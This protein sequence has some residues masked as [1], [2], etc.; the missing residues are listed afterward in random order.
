VRI[1]R[2]GA[3]AD[4]RPVG[5]FLGADGELK[6][7]LANLIGNAAHAMG[8]KGE[9]TVTLAPTAVGSALRL[10]VADSGTGMSAEIS[11]RIFEPFYTTKGVGEGTGLGLSIVYGIVQRWGG[12]IQVDSTPGT[13]TRFSIT[14]PRLPDSP[15]AARGAASTE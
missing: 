13:G 11:A 2:A 8:L 4:G 5:R 10:D 3:L 7:I 14:L 1:R 15:T 12:D 9:V 6:Q